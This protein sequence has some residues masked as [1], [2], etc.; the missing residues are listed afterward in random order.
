[1]NIR[2]FK[3]ERYLAQYEFTAP[4]LLCTSDCET[5]TIHELLEMES[6][7]K[8]RMGN[9]PL[10]YTESQGSPELRSEIAK[11]YDSITADE[12][13]VTS[14]AEEGIFL[15]M[16]VL[17]KPGDHVIV[18]TP[19]YQS[20]HELP[21]SIGCTIS[22]WEMHEVNGSWTMDLDVL[23]SLITPK[24][25]LL[26]INAPHNPTGYTF[27]Q[28][29]WG[30]INLIAQEYQLVILSDEVYRGSEHD[31][32]HAL[33]PMADLNP[34]AISLGVMSKAL[35][36]AGLRIGWIAAKDSDFRNRFQAFK[37]YTTI[38]N[39]GPSE[40][41]SSIALRQKDMILKRNRKIISENLSLL[42]QFIS[43]HSDQLSWSPPVA[44]ST[45]Y[46]R[47]AENLSIEHFCNAVREKQGVLLLPGTVFGSTTPHF[48]LG[49]GRK[50]MPSILSRFEAYLMEAV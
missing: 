8:E 13:I 7:S 33:P 17:L 45:S 1:M 42:H 16:Q 23:I 24:T 21:R 29:D 37:D 25:R 44:G 41:L 26:V 9:F 48:R 5:L 34:N 22:E 10:G 30:E 15:S 6:G 28:K 38:C 18:Q 27:S 49:Y 36:L 43:R 20:L 19:S 3:L 12:I 14:G 39:S 11:W 2:E 46:P 32:R 40:F 35:G 50:N 47:I 4:Y 31:P